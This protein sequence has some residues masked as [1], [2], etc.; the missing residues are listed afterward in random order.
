MASS[1][2]QAAEPPADIAALFPPGTLAYAELHNPAELSPQLAALFKGTALEDSI[3]FIH[4]RKDAGKSLIELRKQELAGLALIASPEM[5]AEFKKL[6]IAAGMTGFTEGGELEGYVVVLTGDSPA[7]GLA[8]RAFLTMHS[9]LRKVGEVSKVPVFQHRSPNIDYDPNG[10]PVIANDKPPTDGPHEPTYA[11]TPGLFVVGTSKVAVSHAVKRFLGEQKDGLAATA[12]FKEAAAAHRQT[13]LFYF[14]NFPEFAARFGA[15][16]RAR[17]GLERLEDL[18]RLTAD[19]D[20]YAWFQ[21]TANPKAVKSVAGCLRFRDGGLALTASIQFDPTQRSPLFDLLSGPGVTAEM[22]RT[23]PQSA[24]VGFT[25]ALPEKNRG[26]VVIA[27]L[28]ALAKAKGELGRLPG[29]AVR[30][31]EEKFKVSIADGLLGKTRAITLAQPTNQEL[32]KGAKAWPMMVLMCEDGT[33]ATAW[34]EF[35]P[36]LIGDLTG[37]PT[38]QP[39]SETVDGVKVFSLPGTGLPWNAPVHYARKGAVFA[40]GLDRKL[41]AAAVTAAPAS[42]SLPTDPVTSLGTLHIGE[43]VAALMDSPQPDGP[44]IPRDGTESTL[45]LNGQPIPQRFIEDYKKARKEFLASLS[46]LPPAAVTARRVGN[47]LRIEVYQPKV[48]NGGL[49]TLIEAGLNWVDQA[50]NMRD[51]NQLGRHW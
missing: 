11:Y 50:S 44:V 29:E 39:A 12:P 33:A 30:E 19:T 8:A 17:G 36:K 43:L 27:F 20:L 9:T 10:V 4:G 42:V 15:A 41:V 7:A 21:L 47:E 38:P 25:V 51:P 28:D 31:L 40:A 48:H 22:L 37:T 32:P 34:E 35:F 13:G 24:T 2:L 26:P 1:S 16:N 3:P 45:L 6:R 18:L 5:L 14:V 46:S 23:A 49:K